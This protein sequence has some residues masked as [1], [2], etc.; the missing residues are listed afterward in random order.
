MF[1]FFRSERAL[2]DEFERELAPHVDAL[3]GAALR[4]TRRPADAEDL[5]QDTVLKAYRFFDRFEAGTNF[6]AWLLRILTN[7]FISRY[8]RAGVERSALENDTGAVA[9]DALLSRDAM[10]GLLDPVGEA[11][12]SLLRAEIETALGELSDDHRVVVVLSDLEELSYREIAE[13]VGV[14]IGTVM[15]RLHRARSHL[16]VRLAAQAEA[17]GLGRGEP[18]DVRPPT[19]LAAFRKAKG[20]GS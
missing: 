10:R 11:Q 8:R 4:M 7:T 14:P 16:K 1:R 15:S 9:G 18:S 3:Y 19:D 12:R 5:V 6:R 17:M 2:K 20:G 13:I